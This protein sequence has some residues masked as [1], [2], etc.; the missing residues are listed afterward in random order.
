M[1]EGW[2]ETDVDDLVAQLE[3]VY[4][5][6]TEAEDRGQRAVELMRQDF[7]WT[8]SIHRVAALTAHAVGNPY[9][10]P[11]EVPPPGT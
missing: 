6:R 5:H 1:A 9:V 2:G 7:D 10:M 8:K 11:K 3:H 4:Q